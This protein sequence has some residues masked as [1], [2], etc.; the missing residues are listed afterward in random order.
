MSETDAMA[1]VK[2]VADAFGSDYI[3]LAP[4]DERRLDPATVG[5]VVAA[6]VL[7]AGLGGVLD[8]IREMAKRGTLS[9]G[10]GVANHVRTRFHR[11]K[12]TVL[13]G[14]SGPTR[15]RE[16]LEAELAEARLIVA[17]IDPTAIAGLTTEAAR[18]IADLLVAQGLSAT[19]AARVEISVEA[20]LSG[21]LTPPTHG[22][23]P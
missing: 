7:S 21:L 6:S 22:V 23:N 10:E 11:Q 2:V 4:P 18:A 16:E 13:S 12:P 15:S 5:L 9:V 20:E 8:A 3:E 1:A 17:G 14:S 19:A